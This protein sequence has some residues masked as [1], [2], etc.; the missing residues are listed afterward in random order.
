MKVGISGVMEYA[1]RLIA[2]V[3]V[4]MN[5]HPYRTM[6]Y[7]STGTNV[8][9][10]NIWF[11]TNGI[12]EYNRKIGKDLILSDPEKTVVF[13]TTINSERDHANPVLRLNAFSG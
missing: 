1:N 4:Q 13:P 9:G 7:R 11:P 2:M 3:D 12:T 6:M 8:E 5:G 10:K